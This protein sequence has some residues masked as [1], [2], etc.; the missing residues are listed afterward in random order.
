MIIVFYDLYLHLSTFFMIIIMITFVV[1]IWHLCF[2][3]GHHI[4]HTEA[5]FKIFKIFE[6]RNKKQNYTTE[7]SLWLRLWT[8]QYSSAW[9]IIISIFCDHVTFQH[10]P[11]PPY[12]YYIHVLIYV[13][14]VIEIFLT[15]KWKQS[16][17]NVISM[18][19]IIHI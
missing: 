1:I 18:G 9:L 11:P 4:D 17:R 19:T 10:P 8:Q 16:S 3:D 14:I 12:L 2:N 13:L 6:I 15:S 5:L 7:S